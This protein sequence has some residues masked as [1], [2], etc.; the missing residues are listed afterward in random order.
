MILLRGYPSAVLIIAFVCSAGTLI[1]SIV[2]RNVMRVLMIT[3]AAKRSLETRFSR[4]P[5]SVPP[6]NPP[7]P[8]NNNDHIMMNAMNELVEDN[9]MMKSKLLDLYQK[10]IDLEQMD[11]MIIEDPQQEQKHNEK[12][13]KKKKK[14]NKKKKKKKKSNKKKQEGQQEQWG[15]FF[16]F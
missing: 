2:R 8:N 3:Q 5:P 9:E 4:A 16:Y 15:S 14:K 7:T 12:K 6:Q 10:H 1:Y 13:K 11:E